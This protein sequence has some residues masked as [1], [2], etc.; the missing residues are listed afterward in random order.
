MRTVNA[1]NKKDP[2]SHLLAGIVAALRARRQ[3][4]RRDPRKGSAR[5]LLPNWPDEMVVSL[6]RGRLIE[7]LMQDEALRRE[8]RGKL[9]IGSLD[10][11]TGP[12]T[13]RTGA[14]EVAEVLEAAINAAADP[15]AV[16]ESA[17][18]D[19]DPAVV[20][21]A[22]PYLRGDL[23]LPFTEAIP[24]QRGPGNRDTGDGERNREQRRKSREAADTIKSL[25][26]QLRSQQ[27]ENSQLRSHLSTAVERAERAEADAAEL[28]RQLPSRREREALAAASTQQDKLEE[29]KRVLTQDRTD[30]RAQVRQLRGQVSEAQSAL[31]DALERLDAEARGRRKLEA[32][33]GDDAGRRAGRLIPL[34]RR[35]A[36][37]L[38]QSAARLPDGLAKTRQLRR[39]RS[40]DDL[41]K[42]LCD[43]YRLDAAEGSDSASDVSGQS[44]E[45][46]RAVGMQ[47][48]P[49]GVTV[50]PVG[51]AAS[52]GGSAILVEAGGTRV[53]VDAGLKPQSHITRPGP[54]RIE[55]VVRDR[56]DAVVVT[57]AHA[58]HAGFVPWVVERQRRTQV[59]CSPQTKALLPVAWADS[60]RVM[61]AEADGISS[62]DNQ[63]EP[64]YGEA[65][66]WNSPCS[67]Q[68]ISSARPA[69]SSALGISA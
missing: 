33:L 6:H 50:T 62:R 30:H 59:L 13:A 47:V 53:L 49:R 57:H 38:R 42:L 48:R 36:V 27:K 40:L 37:D 52:I 11:L 18:T 58:D 26:G 9:Q 65:E 69:S 25:R 55:E 67:L 24:S 34:A 19:D 15:V 4:P 39:A 35:E 28:R 66:T 45:P 60:V 56:V 3:L 29:M 17:A 63:V 64:P 8:V 54:D 21:A 31:Q 2:A 23:S 68:A 1:S 20:A 22:A 61:R 51:G 10:D 43:L 5:W 32:D 16:L 44:A 7:A 46:Q 41:V 14:A 12:G